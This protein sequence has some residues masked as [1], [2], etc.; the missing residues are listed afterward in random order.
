MHTLQVHQI[1]ALTR[2]RLVVVS[3]DTPLL[4]AA[5]NLSTTQIGL[6]VVCNADRVMV[7][8]ISK[9]DILRHISRCLGSACRMACGEVMTTGV[10]A[11]QPSDLLHDVL[12]I[13]QARGLIHLPVLDADQCPVGVVN[14]RDALRTL[15]AQGQYEQSQLFDYVMGVGYH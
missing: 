9:T 5:Q 12:S 11:C 10:V 13:M 3:L 1:D 8:V 7:G 14:A 6:L 15:V 2:S 4:S